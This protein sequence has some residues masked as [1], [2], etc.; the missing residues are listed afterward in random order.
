MRIYLTLTLTS[1]KNWCITILTIGLDTHKSQFMKYVILLFVFSA[2]FANSALAQGERETRTPRAQIVHDLGLDN[3]PAKQAENL[4]LTTS[5]NIAKPDILMDVPKQSGVK[6]INKSA[7]ASEAIMRL[8]NPESQS[9]TK[10]GTERK[11]PD[12]IKRKKDKSNKPKIAAFYLSAEEYLHLRRR[13]PAPQMALFYEI[14]SGSAQQMDQKTGMDT[15]LAIA[16]KVKLILGKDYAGMQVDDNLTIY[17]FKLNR[18]LK[19]KPE[20]GMD[21]KATGKTLLE[22]TSIYAKTYRDII[23]V[24]GTTQDGRLKKIDMGRG[25]SLDAFWI[26]SAM[27]WSTKASEEDLI[28]DKTDKSLRVH[29]NGEVIF[30][31]EFAD[32]TYEISGINKNSLLAF[33][34]LEWPIHPLILRVLYTYDSPPKWFEM[35]SYGPTAPQGQ[36]QV[37]TLVKRVDDQGAFPL[38]ANAVGAAQRDKVSPLVFLINEAVHNRALGG[39]STVKELARDFN[40]KLATQQYWQAWIIG[41]KYMAYSGDC[42]NPN[43]PSICKAVTKIEQTRKGDLPKHIQD[44]ITAIGAVNR[45]ELKGEIIAVIAPYLDKKETPAFIVRTA[46]MTRAK[47]KPAQAVAMG[48][49]DINAEALLLTALAKD[50]YDPKTYVGLAQVLAAK[51]AFEQSWDVY[52]ALRAGIPTADAERLKINRLEKKLRK[53]APGYFL[54]E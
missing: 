30:S 33:A 2:V 47:M 11:K 43:D 8:I 31:A 25:V 22:N 26:E 36:K 40:A 12:Q 5:Y 35:L 46:A 13:E 9:V 16:K 51:G 23:A 48:V 24:R 38:P 3:A 17:D 6:E 39:I 52:D 44:Y 32:E 42:K 20:F 27:S 49:S 50:P 14:T 53:T 1:R 21:G 19:V 4:P 34:H 18:V 28:L 29:R 54:G 37:W 41:Q 15:G 45:P 7:S 10:A